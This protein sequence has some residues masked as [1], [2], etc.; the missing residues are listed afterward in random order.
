VS[1]SIPRRLDDAR[2]APKLDATLMGMFCQEQAQVT[3]C[4]QSYQWAARCGQESYGGHNSVT[5]RNISANTFLEMT[6]SDIWNATQ[7]P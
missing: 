5:I 1:S 2:L 3:A 7:P 6:A 4:F